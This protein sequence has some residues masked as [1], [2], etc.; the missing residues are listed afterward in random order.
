MKTDIEV[1]RELESQIGYE[2]PNL[3][4]IDLIEDKRFIKSKND[5]LLKRGYLL[6]ENGVLI[7]LFLDYI[8]ANTYNSELL[9]EL[10]G[11]KHLSLRKAPLF[12]FEQLVEN[13]ELCYLDL[14][15]NQLI[16][17][18]FLSELKKLN[19][20]DLS[21]NN[22]SDISFLKETKEL[23]DLN[24]SC[25]N[26][27]DISYLKEL[28]ELVNL[29]LSRNDLGDVSLLEGLKELKTLNLY[30]NNLRELS[31]LKKLKGITK[32]DL[33]LNKLN[34]FSFLR[35]IVSLTSID[36]DN[37]NLSDISF[38]KELKGIIRLN[39]SSNSQI[40][41]YS[42]LKELKKLTKLNLSFNNLNDISFL[43]E[44]SGLRVL[45]LYN[46]NISDGYLLQELTNLTKLNLYNNNLSNVSF[47]SELT[48]LTEL[49]ISY[50]SL[51]EVSFLKELLGLTELNLAYNNLN[52]ISSLK[53][54]VRLRKLNL[55][56]NKI[57]EISFLKDLVNLTKLDLSYNKISDFSCLKVLKKLTDLNLS[58]NNLGDTSFFKDLKELTKLNLSSNKLSNISF[59]KEL[60]ALTELKLFNNGISEIAFI[61][62]LKGL[63]MLDL[64]SNIKIKDF[65]FLGELKGLTKLHLSSNN[66]SNVSFLRGLKVLTTLHLSSNCLKDV[67]YLQELKKLTSLNLYN[68]KLS[69]ISF[70]KELGQLTD[71]DIEHNPIKSPPPTIADLGIDA[72]RKYFTELNNGQNNYLF[73]AKLLI[74]GESGAGKTTFARKLKNENSELPKPKETTWGVDVD[75]LELNIEKKYFPKVAQNEYLGN[76][77]KFNLNIWDFGGQD[78]YHAT[79]RFFLSQRS[80]YVLVSDERKEDTDFKY[81]LQMVEKFGKDSPLIIIQNQKDEKSREIDE[82]SLKSSFSNLKAIL[83]VN[84][85]KIDK[86]FTALKN[87]IIHQICNL[88]Q[89]GEPVPE[90]WRKVRDELEK[91]DGNFIAKSKYLAI[92]E[93][94]KITDN[95]IQNLL[96][97]YFHEIG[98][99][100]HFQNDVVLRNTIFLKSEWVTKAVYTIVE[101]KLAKEVKFGRLTANDLDNLWKEENYQNKFT[102]LVQLMKNFLLIY[103]TDDRNEYVMPQLL[104]VIKPEYEWNLEDNRVIRY[105]YKKFMPKGILWMLIVKLSYYIKDDCLV[106]KQ[107]VILEKNGTEAEII[108]NYE[109]GIITIKVRGSQK[110]S[111][112]TTVTDVIDMIS[113]KMNIEEV[114]KLIPCNCPDCIKSKNTP[115]H[116][117]YSKLINRL[118]NNREDDEC[119]FPPY[120]KVN[121]RSLLDD[122]I[123]QKNTLEMK[124]FTRERMIVIEDQLKMLFKLLSDYEKVIM[125]GDDPKQKMKAELEIKNIRLSIENIQKELAIIPDSNL[126]YISEGKQYEVSRDTFNYQLAEVMQKFNSVQNL[127]KSSD[128]K[129]DTIKGTIEHHDKNMKDQ[130]TEVKGE[131]KELQPFLT[132]IEKDINS[133]EKFKDIEKLIEELNINYKN[134]SEELLTQI[135]DWVEIN[136]DEL[137]GYQLKLYEELKKSDSWKTK[138]KLK[139][140]L[141]LA[142][143]HGID[144]SIEHEVYLN[145]WLKKLFKK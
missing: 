51:T 9:K 93:K 103:E 134:V 121:I 23:S 82:S 31:F 19:S 119:D 100:L 143:V 117:I 108:E 77:I 16:D 131:I 90:N 13:P 30:G 98:V 124:D 14:S 41:D 2:L 129:L 74:L 8:P 120:N 91:I 42:V 71:I 58:Y 35:E 122:Y 53:E 37:N 123:I 137:K 7:A 54:L 72:I 83:P 22:I 63:T 15:L 145:K 12:P 105:D 96:S 52:D 47:L 97:T 38:L 138:A 141:P 88:P 75:S 43:K 92:C 87:E 139:F 80:V 133:T 28:S 101:S 113:D 45:D 44:L 46:N 56:Y 1:I 49:D 85:A 3:N 140:G 95:E 70:L 102:D 84:F 109:K 136:T 62:K 126:Q 66:L 36:L 86:R 89:I 111:L 78:I 17:V 73:E 104:R 128:E 76:N 18:S 4:S 29:D 116:F 57:T 130:F 11:L 99:F 40:R 27:V 61:K 125:L 24:L 110:K 25:N 55:Y 65:S 5:L 60:N 68:N 21:D 112:M 39:L 132:R 135:F 144:L 33:S 26:L 142:F 64:S 6:N 59:L 79:H 32:L 20:I 115:H 107:G 48:G 118:E 94:Y 127:L 10:E 69:D 106:W 81:W 34:D 114:D 50:N 67:S